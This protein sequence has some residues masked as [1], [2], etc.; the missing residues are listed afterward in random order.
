MMYIG[1]GTISTQ[2]KILNFMVIKCLENLLNQ[3]AFAELD[4][5]ELKNAIIERSQKS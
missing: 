3:K 5:R 2:S 4:L 1:N